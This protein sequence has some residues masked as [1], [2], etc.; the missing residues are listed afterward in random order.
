MATV[1][2]SSVIQDVG[3]TSVHIGSSVTLH[4]YYN[5]TQVASHY[6]WYRQRLGS[7]PT[8]LA[9]IYKFDTPSKIL[10]WLEKHPRFAVQ[11]QEGQ[12]HLHISYVQAQDTALYFCGSSHNNVVEFGQ[13]MFLNVQDPAE[14]VAK[15]VTQSPSLVLADPGSSVTFGCSVRPG[16]CTEE[17]SIY[18]FKQG[19]GLGLLHT[20]GPEYGALNCT[21]HLWKPN[22]SWFDA[23]T[24]YCAVASCGHVLFGSGT[25]LQFKERETGENGDPDVHIRVLVKLSLLRMGVLLLIDLFQVYAMFLCIAVLDIV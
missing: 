21:Y 13:G 15:Y 16:T 7:G 18:W 1:T 17:S 19:S 4:C 8:V 11:R 5:S 14:S 12:N 24:Y 23:G 22:V 10:V 3:I 6:S 2:L 20:E 9:T 25:V